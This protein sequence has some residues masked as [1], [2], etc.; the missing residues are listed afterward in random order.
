MLDALTLAAERAGRE[1]EHTLR[2]GLFIC[3]LA[4][5][6]HPR[7][8]SGESGIRQLLPVSTG[9]LFERVDHA[10]PVGHWCEQPADRAQ[11]MVDLAISLIEDRPDEPDDGADFLHATPRV[12]HRFVA[13]R[14]AD[15]MKLGDGY[16]KLTQHEP[17]NFGGYR[18]PFL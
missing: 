16:F 1:L 3:A 2:P 5:A 10:L 17:P 18:R 6:D 11:V 12:V 4:V 13:L 14:I 9:E 7:A 8:C 15:G